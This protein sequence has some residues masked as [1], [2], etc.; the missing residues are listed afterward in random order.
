MFFKHRSICLECG[1]SYPGKKECF[2]R[3]IL[4]HS[5][6][7]INV[8]KKNGRKLWEISREE[9]KMYK[10]DK[11]HY[12]IALDKLQN[13]V[14]N[15]MGLKLS[16]NFKQIRYDSM[17]RQLPWQ[18]EADRIARENRVMSFTPSTSIT[19]PYCHSTN[20]SKISTIDRGISVGMTGLASGK[21][22]KQWH[23]NKCKSNF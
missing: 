5:T 6:N 1:C 18:V 17:D 23:C 10:L 11:E 15:T 2:D 3:C 13:Y 22:G 4:C 21:L 8:S 16:S 9:E 20:V 14:V 12:G 7:M 19:C